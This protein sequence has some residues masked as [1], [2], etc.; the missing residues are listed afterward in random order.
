ML[1]RGGSGGRRAGTDVEFSAPKSFS[2]Q[3]LVV[4]DT[5]LLAVHQQ[6]VAVA[7]AHLE[8]LTATRVTERGTTTVA[9]TGKAVIAQFE[10]TTSRAGDPD[11]HSHVVVLNCT[12]RADGQWRSV[13]NATVFQAQ[14]LL[15]SMYLAEL[16]KGAKALGYRLTQGPHGTPELAHISR[17]Q[18]THFSTRAWLTDKTPA[19]HFSSRFL[20]LKHKSKLPALGILLL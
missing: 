18:L 14:R 3:A 19:L 7:R 13:D 9:T 10:H 4:G 15:Y 20:P 16:A 6:A 17:A 8:T 11:L 5:R 12:Q 2:I 1:H